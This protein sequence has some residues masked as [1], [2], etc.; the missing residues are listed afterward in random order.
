MGRYLAQRVLMIVPVMLGVTIIVFAMMRL[1]PGDPA[2]AMGGP[3]ATPETLAEIRHYL[4][5]DQP[6]PVQYLVW[7]QHAVQGDLGRSI[8]QG[9]QV[10]TL[11][12]TRLPNS[13]L[14]AL[15]SFALATILGVLAGVVA[16]LNRGS[17]LDQGIALVNVLGF[18]TPAFFLGLLLI[19]VFAFKFPIFPMSGMRSVEGSSGPLDVAAH[20]VLP[21]ITLAAVPTTVIARTV[22]SSVLETAGQD[23]VRT[24]RAKGLARTAVITGHILKN[25]LI[26]VVTL[27]GLQA[28]FLLGGAAIVEVVFSYPGIGNLMIESILERDLPVTQ[29][30]VLALAVVYVFVNI[31]ADL[32]QGYLD[33]RIRFV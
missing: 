33:P 30:C 12:L 4:G 19:V 3:R 14:L 24:A 32:A 5:L 20:L 9:Q 13:A 27:L 8:R 7:L 17:W 29:G 31:A 2:V 21:A 10:T 23:Y 18:S 11:L 22:R 15:V 6:L 26:P 28:G 16:A 25:A 1:A